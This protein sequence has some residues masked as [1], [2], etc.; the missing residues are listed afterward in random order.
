MLHCKSSKAPHEHHLWELTD[1]SRDSDLLSHTNTRDSQATYLNVTAT[2][3]PP[4]ASD[5]WLQ[6]LS[7]VACYQAL[8][9]EEKPSCSSITQF[10]G[11]CANR[12]ALEKIRNA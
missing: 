5:L 7:K 9:L 8:L 2:G 12:E 1:I 3:F 11:I 6:A 10:W 4:D